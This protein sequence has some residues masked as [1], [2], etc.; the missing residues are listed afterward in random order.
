MTGSKLVGLLT[1]PLVSDCWNASDNFKH[2]VDNSVTLINIV[3]VLADFFFLVRWTWD[4]SALFV[5]QSFS[6][7]PL[8]LIDNRKFPVSLLQLQLKP[9]LYELTGYHKENRLWCVTLLHQ[10]PFGSHYRLRID[11]LNTAE[12]SGCLKSSPKSRNNRKI[13]HLFWN[14]QGRRKIG[15]PHKLLPTSSNRC[16][17]IRNKFFHEKIQFILCPSVYLK[18]FSFNFKYRSSS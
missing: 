14:F 18:L 10:P 6:H 11:R 7:S 5:V 12:Y 15:F 8:L 4:S 13:P 17:R 2:C 16:L 3:F 1:H 9:V